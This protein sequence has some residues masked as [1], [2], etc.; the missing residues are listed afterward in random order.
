M[1]KT[2]VEE[3]RAALIEALNVYGDP[4]A[5]AEV[6]AAVESLP[7][8]VDFNTYVDTFT[9]AARA[10]WQR[11]LDA[12]TF[13]AQELEWQVVVMDLLPMSTTTH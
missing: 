3:C 9:D 1:T 5:T 6:L 11:K 8:D 12:A 13:R 4:A 2:Q 7:A 10:V